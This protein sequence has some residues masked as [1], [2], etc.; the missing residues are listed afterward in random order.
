MEVQSRDAA[1][2][3]AVEAGDMETAKKMLEDEAARKGYSGDTGYMGTFF[4]GS[5]PTA[6]GFWETPDERLEAW[7]S[8]D[9][10]DTQSLGDYV[11]GI[12]ISDL[13]W[14]STN[15]N[16][17]RSAAG[18]ESQRAIQ[19]AVVRAQ[20]GEQGVTIKMYRA[21]PDD[22]KESH[23]RNGDWITPSRKYAEEHIKMQD[24][25]DHGR[26]IEEDVPIENVWWDGNDINEWGYDDGKETVYKNTPNNR[27]EL[28]VTYDMNGKLIPLSKRFDENEDTASYRI[29]DDPDLINELEDGE[30]EEVYRVMQVIDGKLYPPMAAV[31]EGDLV[32]P[33]RLGVIEQADEH[34]EL[35][36]FDKNSKPQFLLNKGQGKGSLYA[37]YNPYWHISRTP[38]ND[39]FTGAYQ[40]PNLVVVKTLV[41]KNELTSGYRAKYAKDTVGEMSWH[42][43]TV[44]GRLA[45]LGKPRRVILSRYDKPMEIMTNEEVAHMIADQLKETDIAI[46]YNV[47]WPQLR[48]ELEKLGVEISDEASGR[49]A[50]EADFG[51]AEYITD[52]KI[53]QMNDKAKKG[54]VRTPEAKRAE[55]ERLGKK[56]NTPIKIIED[57]NEIT[58]ENPAIQAKRRKAAGWYDRKTGEIYVVLPN[59]PNVE[60]TAET[61]FHETVGHKGLRELIGEKRYGDFL[62]EVYEHAKSE[63]RKRIT[64]LAEKNGWNFEKATDEY[65]GR[66]AEKGFED[67]DAH[68]RSIW[69]RIKKAVLDAINKFLKSL[70]F[71]KWV[72]LGDNELRYML[73]R[74]K[75]HLERGKDD[76]ID[77]ARDMVK[78]EELG[79]GDDAVYSMGDSP[80][81][82]KDRQKR[83]V[84]RKGTVMPRLNSAEVKVVDVPRHS[85]T[86]HDALSQ[87]E[88]AAIER[89]TKPA[90]ERGKER[91]SIPQHYNNNGVTFD[92]AI[93]QKS[94][95]EAGNHASNSD[96]IGV[97]I[98]VMDNLHK[99]I[100]N[101]IEYE[102]HPDVKKKNGVRRWENGFNDNVLMHRF[103]GAVQID[104]TTYRV[105]TTMKEHKNQNIPNGHYTYEVTKIEVLD[106]QTTRP[107]SVSSR[108]SNTSNGRPNV[109]DVFVDT[110]KLLKDVEKS[111]DEGK[112]ILA[113]SKLA[114]D[115]TALYRDPSETE[116][117]WSDQS[118]GMQERIT[119]AATRLANNHQADKTLRNDAM[120]QIGGNL[121]DLRK[122]MSLQRTFDM[123]TVKRVG[124]L[125]RVL[126]NAGYLDGLS[127]TEVKR[128]LAAVKN[129]VGHNDI[130]SSVQKV[131]DIMV[132]NQLKRAE[133]TLHS[134][135]T[136]KGSKVDARGVEVQGQLDP[137]GQTVMKVFKKSRGMELTDI[138]DAIADAQN[139]MGSNDASVADEASLEYTGLQL[140]QDYV[141]NIKQSKADEQQLRQELKQSHEETSERDR[142][143]DAYRQYVA[144]VEDAIRQ[145]KIERAQS[146]FDLVGRL[147]DSLR[148]SIANAQAFKEA[149]K[150]RVRAIQHNANS[151]MEGRPTDEHRSNDGTIKWLNNAFAKTLFAPLATFDQMLRLF[152]RKSANGEGYL[153][154][155]F[156]RGWVDAR[157]KEI[158]GVRAKYAILDD[159][160]KE[161]FGGKVKTWSDLIRKVGSLPKATVTFWDGGEMREHTL[162]QGNLMYIYMVNKMIDGKMKLRKMGISEEDVAMIEEEL[163]PRLVSLADWL[164]DEF[165]VDTRNEYN[166]THKRMF[167]ASMAAIENYFPLKILAN[168]RADKPE[169]LDNPDR[170]D[171]ISTATGSIIKRRRNALALDI[172]G[173]DA[174][175]VIVDHIAQIEHWNAYAEWNRDL[176]TL[177]TYKHF[178]NQVQNMTTIYGNGKEL[179]KKFND[180]CQMAAG[181]Y[182]PP[183]AM[184]DEGAVN[185]AKG[186]TAA[187]VSFR[188]FT[189]LKQFLSW[190][191]Y[192]PEVRA[193]YMLADLVNPAGAWKWCMDNLPIFNER[194]KSRMVGD[195]RLAK[196]DMDWKMWRSRF[197]QIASR[198]GMSPNAFVDA[199]TVA[200]GAHSMYRTRLS[201]YLRDGYSQEEAEHRANQDAEVL[202]NQTQQSSEGPFTST[203]QVD[204]SWLSVLFTVF[205][206]A[207]MAYTRQLHDA[208]RN[209]KRNLTGNYAERIEFMKK[210]YV[211][212][213][214]DEAQAERNAKRKYRR[215]LLKDTLRVATFGYI[216]QLAW[217]LGAYLPYILFGSDD[218]EKQKMWDDVWS[219]TLFGWLEGF[220]GGDVL[221]QGGGMLVNGEGNPANLSKDMPLTSDLGTILS[222]F[223]NGKHAEAFSDMVNLIVQSGI[224]VNPQSITDAA[225]AI[226]DACG[227]DPALAHEA[228]ICVARILQVPQSPLWVTGYFLWVEVALSQYSEYSEHEERDIVDASQV[229]PKDFNL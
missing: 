116:D 64:K 30:W 111:Y 140:A 198:I 200:I 129:S 41:P 193:D 196:S 100:N 6:N 1:Y 206:N 34:P 117:I 220:T 32:E 44:S 215:Q 172:T 70:K 213:G 108:N 191:A 43:G 126:M 96:N 155:R 57:V 190:P 177:R 151:D 201:Q 39:Q 69:Q 217:N 33:I 182:R 219:H 105:I 9:Y 74:S 138:E 150:E 107:L 205:R 212:D 82:F 72:K 197:M 86:G 161:L 133:Q 102:E 94:I 189:A 136:I 10:E 163:D 119:A 224:G 75:E 131:M 59:N 45:E 166:E 211:R 63:V 95:M 221:S 56:F 180:V 67:F 203:M 202:Y 171:G 143:T 112:K 157:Q 2:Q 192:I 93:S 216:L 226:M 85:Y 27:K 135:E 66:L 36:T 87:A 14:R 204:R 227:D 214:I 185:F 179:W 124:D 61:V 60:F 89:Y 91:E 51:K 210:Q 153:Y 103:V 120:R 208:L 92:Y 184:L 159:K 55:A 218:D 158:R 20:K 141:Q 53:A 17:V 144:S 209:F 115:D 175:H 13:A 26:I 78:R 101:S 125:A 132:D 130:E 110:A 173:A 122:A 97:H 194:W 35:I 19:K 106:G 47:V 195:P 188:V 90:T 164:Q 81:N 77:V 28:A 52:K 99:V 7:N 186:V 142:V 121:A 79:L 83:A 160:A 65:L 222:K 183:R 139:R 73:W 223:G 62:R 49:V 31:R 40:R 25:S 152:G 21:V 11:R 225:L 109:S 58:H 147:T 113:E 104:G 146:Y 88:N 98:A 80:D 46:P 187:K 207:S 165:L 156:M 127:S 169:D 12:D 148:E 68:E 114:D 71:P 123:T 84:E 18:R 24:W 174:L 199:L 48:D 178:R 50:D 16:A 137:N 22:I 128:L 118:M 37:A 23:F 3:R 4:N 149:E 145:N 38:L 5:A 42:S 168:A 181:T 162:T 154:N 134:L 170:S 76:P 228:T 176:N 229:C 8:G 54:M 15:P 167:G 29:V